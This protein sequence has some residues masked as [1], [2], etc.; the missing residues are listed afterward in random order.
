MP[1]SDDGVRWLGVAGAFA[2]AAILAGWLRVIWKSSRLAADAFQ[3][4]ILALDAARKTP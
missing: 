4:E 3:K 2:S 1:S